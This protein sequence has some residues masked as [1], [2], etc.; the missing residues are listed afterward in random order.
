METMIGEK[1]WRHVGTTAAGVKIFIEGPMMGVGRELYKINELIPP[2]RSFV[3]GHFCL[4]TRTLTEL[5]IPPHNL[6]DREGRTRT[7]FKDHVKQ[8]AYLESVLTWYLSERLRQPAI[9]SSL[10]DIFL[11]RTDGR[12]VTILFVADQ[13]KHLRTVP[14]VSTR[15]HREKCVDNLTQ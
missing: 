3:P 10:S 4:D 5:F 13:C 2:T 8:S 6:E 11:R 9:E 1:S 14:T 15:G 7:I 12:S